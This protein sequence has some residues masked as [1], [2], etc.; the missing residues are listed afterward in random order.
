MIR[1]VLAD[2]QALLLDGL[3]V[4]LGAEA[5]IEVVGAARD[6]EEAI[7]LARRHRP[8]IVLC[9][10]RMPR[11]DGVAATRRIVDELPG[12]RVIALTTY[13][14][15]EL[16]L[17]ALQAGASAYLLKDLPAAELVHAIRA[18][19]DGQTILQPA[20]AG[21]I[22]TALSRQ[23]APRD[24]GPERLTDRETEVLRLMAA[25]LRNKDIAERL[26]VS[27]ATVK[28]HVNNIFA[29]LGCRDRAEAVLWAVRHGVEK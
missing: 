6:G 8:D 27:E 26:V 5:G 4:I 16:V 9:D 10:L 25:G 24:L 15:D 7:A 12:T 14:H 13:D 28:T 17:Q 22:L 21:R 3:R 23:V 1:V 2:D 18:V 29:K 20:A 19:A 11:L